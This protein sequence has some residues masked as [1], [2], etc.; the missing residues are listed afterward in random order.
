MGCR[1]GWVGLVNQTLSLSSFTLSK[2][3]TSYIFYCKN[4]EALHCV[5]GCHSETAKTNFR[6]GYLGNVIST[7]TF[8]IAGRSLAFEVLYTAY[9]YKLFI[10]S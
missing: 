1:R 2:F 6:V 10:Y 7:H 9:Q 8:I 5:K 3:D 4:E